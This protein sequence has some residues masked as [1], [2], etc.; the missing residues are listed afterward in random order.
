MATAA[1][2][3][4]WRWIGGDAGQAPEPRIPLYANINRAPV[5]RVTQE[6][7]HAATAAVGAGFSTIKLAP[8]DGPAQGGES[9]ARTG[10]EHVAAVRRAVGDQVAVLIDLHHK[11]TPEDLGPILPELEELG[12]GWL[13]DAV[14]VRDGDAL[15]WL[16]ARTSLP[17]AGGETLVDP[18]EIAGVVRSGLVSH[19]LLDPK[20]MGGPLA[21]ARTVERA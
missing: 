8:F 17:I 20:F 4:L 13:E 2:Q 21:F 18:H 19:L 7:V 5:E 1:G 9:L 16:A 14:D 10:I 12:V 3:A 6:F 11:L 15:R